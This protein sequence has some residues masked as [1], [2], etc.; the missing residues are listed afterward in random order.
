MADGGGVTTAGWVVSLGILALILCAVWRWSGTALSPAADIDKKYMGVPPPNE[1]SSN[2]T[3][4]GN[5]SSDSEYVARV[6]SDR[7][8]RGTPLL[9]TVTVRAFVLESLVVILCGLVLVDS[10][11]TILDWFNEEVVASPILSGGIAV[12][13]FVVAL[14]VGAFRHAF[15]SMLSRAGALPVV[16]DRGRPKFA[17]LGE[18]VPPPIWQYSPWFRAAT[19]V[20]VA[21]PSLVG[22]LIVS[23]AADQ[24]LKGAFIPTL[25]TALVLRWLISSIP[26]RIA[27]RQM[28][29][30]E[31]EL[32]KSEAQE[33]AIRQ[34]S[35]PRRGT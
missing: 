6:A 28:A 17:Y 8:Y 32:E 1:N 19:W 33:E 25:I 23:M 9:E 13:C 24:F 14:F 20:L 30:S 12:L 21:A 16:D 35:A 10:G 5:S 29:R 31:A 26:E 18:Y 22:A 7:I 3:K 27:Q 15:R 4:D 2:G 11:A 34:P